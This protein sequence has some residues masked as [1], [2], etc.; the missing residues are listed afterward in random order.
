MSFLRGWMCVVEPACPHL[1]QCTQLVN[2]IQGGIGDSEL[3]T[4]LRHLGE[5]PRE[6]N[7][8]LGRRDYREHFTIAYRQLLG[9]VPYH[10]QVLKVALEGRT[11]QMVNGDVHRFPVEVL[12]AGRALLESWSGLLTELDNH[13]KLGSRSLWTKQETQGLAKAYLAFD[14]AYVT[15]EMHLVRFLEHLET[16][17]REVLREIARYDR[18]F[19]RSGAERSREGLL[20]ALYRLNSVANVH[21]QGRD[22]FPAGVWQACEEVA[23]EP[24]H[25]LRPVA[26]RAMSC[27]NSLLG[28]VR[29]ESGTNFVWVH[30]SLARCPELT[31]ALEVWESAWRMAAHVLLD[32]AVRDAFS[33]Y[34][35][36]MAHTVETYPD[37]REELEESGVDALLHLPRALLGLGEAMRPLVLLVAASVVEEVLESARGQVGPVR[38]GAP[39]GGSLEGASMKLQRADPKSWNEMVQVVIGCVLHSSDQVPMEEGPARTASGPSRLSMSHDE[40][41]VPL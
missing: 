30:A 32:R 7:V 33:T 39:V 29:K 2:A 37:F 23:Q 20:A 24:E 34:V 31:E 14:R 15:F 5:L 21:G 16:R 22:S 27:L 35:G 13:R 28:F 12:E 3:Q 8:S 10:T 17:G 18:E 11:E 40:V 36:E 4:F 41:A 26:V 19:T 1:Q 38:W 25:A 6:M 9:R